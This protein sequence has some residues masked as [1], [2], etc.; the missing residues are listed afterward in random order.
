MFGFNKRSGNKIEAKLNHECEELKRTLTKDTDPKTMAKAIFIDFGLGAYDSY[1]KELGLDFSSE[2]I[3]RLEARL[4]LMHEQMAGSKPSDD[5]I[6]GF[7]KMFGG[8]L[9]CVMMQT[10]WEWSL[11]GKN[12]L[13]L[14][15]V[16]V[17][18][19]GKRF[20]VLSKVYKRLVNGPE[21]NVWDAYQ[22]IDKELYE[23]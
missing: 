13:D 1:G 18:R 11:E 20:Y 22:I 9:G 23:H 2:S 7:V 6:N 5:T 8:Y 17:E 19:D 21:D 16:V 12:P 10:G 4:A 14:G 15:K 3:K